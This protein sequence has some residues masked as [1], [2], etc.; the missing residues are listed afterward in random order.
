MGQSDGSDMEA[1]ELGNET[2]GQ[3]QSGQ[4]CGIRDRDGAGDG[5]RSHPPDFRTAQCEHLLNQHLLF[6]RGHY[7]PLPVVHAGDL[8]CQGWM[9]AGAWVR[10]RLN[11]W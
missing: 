11:A 4:R 8:W 3:C 1:L 10:L 7:I 5:P 6:S 2:S 9:R